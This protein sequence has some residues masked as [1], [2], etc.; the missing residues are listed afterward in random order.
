MTQMQRFLI[1]FIILIF[2]PVKLSAQVIETTIAEDVLVKDDSL[3]EFNDDSLGFLNKTPQYF[4]YKSSL[5]YLNRLDTVSHY[6]FIQRNY[7]DQFLRIY[8]DKKILPASR[9]YAF[10][11]NN[12]YYRSVNL[13]NRYFGFAEQI[14][15]GKMSLY[16]IDDLNSYGEVKT[17]SQDGNNSDY[18]NYLL[19]MDYDRRKYRT[20]SYQ[21]YISFDFNDRQLIPVKPQELAN[22]YMKVCPQASNYLKKI[23][24]NTGSKTIRNLL[25]INFFTSLFASIIISNEINSTVGGENYKTNYAYIYTGISGVAYITYSLVHRKRIVKRENMQEAVKRYNACV[26]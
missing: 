25:A 17:I 21:Y 2:L 4:Y 10:T 24:G 13:G 15:S 26:K 3:Q 22:Q 14:E 18:S 12:R 11:R 20:E 7:S 16:C 8:N 19:V 9:I 23:A 1:R 6:T 5:I